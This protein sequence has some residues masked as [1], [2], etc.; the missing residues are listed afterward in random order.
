MLLLLKAIMSFISKAAFF[1]VFAIFV[2]ITIRRII[3]IFSLVLSGNFTFYYLNFHY[4]LSNKLTYWI[5]WLKEYHIWF[6]NWLFNDNMVSASTV[7]KT[8]SQAVSQYG[9]GPGQL[10]PVKQ[11]IFGYVT[12]YLPDLS[13]IYPDWSVVGYTAGAIFIV[14]TAYLFYTGD[15]DPIPL[16]KK[17]LSLISSYYLWQEDTSHRDSM[18]DDSSYTN[19]VELSD[20]R[21]RSI[22]RTQ[23]PVPGSSYGC[24]GAPWDCPVSRSSQQGQPYTT[25]WVWPIVIPS[26]SLCLRL[27]SCA[28]HHNHSVHLLQQMVH[29]HQHHLIKI[30]LYPSLCGLME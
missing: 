16:G 21:N 20:L 4:D 17:I 14:G 28:A 15:I 7:V 2:Y 25:G 23:S 19:E 5:D 30:K 10:H 27:R 29:L 18:P 26:C 1:P 8:A 9:P 11:T 12:E 3:T 24:T 22:S 13:V 6:H